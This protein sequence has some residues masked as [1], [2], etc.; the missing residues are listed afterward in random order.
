MGYIAT[1]PVNIPVGDFLEIDF[2]LVDHRPGV[3]PETFV[4]ELVHR[5]VEREKERQALR[6]DGPALRGFQWKHLFLPDGTDLRTSHGETI[7]F[8]KVRGDRIVSEDGEALTPSQFANRRAKG[9][10]A[11]R[12]VWLRFPGNEQWVRADDC[13]ERSNRL[14]S[15][16][17][18]TG[19]I[20]SREAL[21][22]SWRRS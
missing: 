20:E 21:I 9:R 22:Y 14:P 15:K 4:I 7:E 1:R 17:S 12:F 6:Q 16:R 18:K 8:A 13:R 10:N 19:P 3:R 2:Y 5:W 11:W